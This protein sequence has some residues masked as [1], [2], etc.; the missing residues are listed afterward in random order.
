MNEW[1][2]KEWKT[3]E[4]IYIFLQTFIIHIWAAVYVKIFITIVFASFER[5]LLLDILDRISARKLGSR[6]Q[7]RFTGHRP[8]VNV[9][10]FA[11]RKQRWLKLDVCYIETEHIR[12]S[13]EI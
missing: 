8:A 11:D 4:S 9:T 5:D 12:V 7:G 2:E 10:S 1:K 13:L 6:G 3:G